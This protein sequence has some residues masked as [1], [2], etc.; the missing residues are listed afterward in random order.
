MVLTKNPTLRNVDKGVSQAPEKSK[1]KRPVSESNGPEAKKRKDEARKEI[2]KWKKSLEGRKVRCERMVSQMEGSDAEAME[3]IK[4]L[5]DRGLSFFFKPVNGYILN[6]VFEFFKNLEIVGDGRVLESR[7]NGKVVVVTPD[8]I[9][10]YLGY[11]RPRPEEVQFPHPNYS[12]L[13]PE[14][15]AKIVCADP[16]R[17]RGKFSAGMLKDKYRI[18]NKIIHYN[19]HPKG[20]EKEPGIADIEFLHIMMSGMHFDVAEYMWEMIRE[21]RTVTSKRNMPFGQMITQLCIKVKVK[22]V[23]SDL[24]V[25]PEVGPITMRS[26]AKSRSMS[27]GATS[28]TSTQE[29]KSKDIKTRIDEWFQMFLCRQTEIAKEQKKDYNRLRRRVDF[30]VTELEKLGDVKYKSESEE[31]EE[32]NEEQGGDEEENDEEEESD[33]E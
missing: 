13:S 25:P 9:A 14:Q 17:F 6:I 27:R 16:S 33:E 12:R 30:C 19:I 28:A 22:L 8:H 31:E 23:V 4:I 5:K 3:V 21:F 10:S 32:G 15:Y 18:M 11:T 24:M 26:D 1:G 2:A 7:V 20:S 29:P